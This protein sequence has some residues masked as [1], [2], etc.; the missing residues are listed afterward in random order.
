MTVSLPPHR[1]ICVFLWG[2]ILKVKYYSQWK[3]DPNYRKDHPTILDTYDR[4][5]VAQIIIKYMFLGPNE[6][7]K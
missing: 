4:N 2:G 1:R 7:V 3:H 6:R 5:S